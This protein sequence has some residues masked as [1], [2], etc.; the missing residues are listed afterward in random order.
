MIEQHY[1]TESNTPGIELISGVVIQESKKTREFI[2]Q[3]LDGSKR[4]ITVPA[5]ADKTVPMMDNVRKGVH[6]IIRHT[7]SGPKTIATYPARG[8]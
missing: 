1:T 6:V 8:G 7:R 2:V 5:K 3:C 4:V